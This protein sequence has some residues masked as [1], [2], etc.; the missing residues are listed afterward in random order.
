MPPKKPF[1]HKAY[2]QIPCYL[3][4][5]LFRHAYDA[6][7]VDVPDKKRS[8]YEHC[9][10]CGRARSWIAMNTNYGKPGSKVVIGASSYTVNDNGVKVWDH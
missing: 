4:W 3:T 2:R 8:M 1:L 10:I 7:F 6:I 9:A 5:P